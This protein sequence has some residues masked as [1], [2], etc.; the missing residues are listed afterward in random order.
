[1]LKTTA[2]IFA[3]VVMG[4]SSP[5]VS[6]LSNLTYE[7]IKGN[8]SVFYPTASDYG[9]SSPFAYR[10]NSKCNCYKLHA[11][12][13][14]PAPVLTPIRAGMN[15]RLI[16]GSDSCGKFVMI[17]NGKYR[18]GYWHISFSTLYNGKNVEKGDIIAL[19]GAD[20]G[21]AHCSTGPH[22]HFWL[23]INGTSVNPVP[24]IE[25]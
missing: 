11:A 21:I 2:V 15:G 4:I 8:L 19:S 23:S 5:A 1:M 9:I 25:K 17:E 3:L 14:I 7:P 22:I 13:D 10:W 12:I 24:Y 16:V 20:G 18:L 6:N